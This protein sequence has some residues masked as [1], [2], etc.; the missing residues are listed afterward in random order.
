MKNLNVVITLSLFLFFLQEN[1]FLKASSCQNSCSLFDKR[2]SKNFQQE[3]SES[4][5][6]SE[7]EQPIAIDLVAIGDAGNQ[8]DHT[9]YGAVSYDFQIGK[10]D[11]TAREYCAFLNAVAAKDTYGLYDER[12]ASDR[13]VASIQR[14]GESPYYSYAIIDDPSLDRGLL[15]ITYVDYYSA[16]RFCNWLHNG[17]PIGEENDETTE[18]GAYT[19]NGNNIVLPAN[20][21]ASWR[22]PT[23]DEWYKAAYYKGG[24]SHAG[25]WSYPTQKNSLPKNEYEPA[26][27]NYFFEA[28][29]DSSTQ[30]IK[31]NIP[32]IGS[33]IIKD[34]PQV[35]HLFLTPVGYF[36]DVTGVYGTYDMGGDVF[37]WTADKASLFPYSYEEGQIVS[38]GCWELPDFYLKADHSQLIFHPSEKNSCIGFRVVAPMSGVTSKLYSSKN[39]D[40]AHYAVP[41]THSINLGASKATHQKMPLKIIIVIGTLSIVVLCALRLVFPEIISILQGTNRITEIQSAPSEY[42][43]FPQVYSQDETPSYFCSIKR[44][45][46]RSLHYLAYWLHL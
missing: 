42:D 33:L 11:V 43:S 16:M 12:M 1:V 29:Q 19:L 15:P 8:S 26:V 31:F 36:S 46:S 7:E 6:L 39:K 2:E 30:S 44:I 4:S 40:I 22:L 38:G 35:D 45:I 23:E 5:H 27:A 21:D 13:A 28:D 17:Q 24:N 10:Y 9:K 34:L 25:Y 18:M 3:E 20:K 14:S 37:Q 32:K 41:A